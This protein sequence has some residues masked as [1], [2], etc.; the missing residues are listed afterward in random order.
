MGDTP[1][2]D[3]SVI[4]TRLSELRESRNINMCKSV[5][6]ELAYVPTS[7]FKDN[8]E[9]RICTT[10]SKMKKKI[11][12]EH[13]SRGVKVPNATILDVCAIF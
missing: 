12:V 2:W 1:I 10:K 7:S 8:G 4:Y 13:T 5:A 3:T 11:Q 9:I 6:H